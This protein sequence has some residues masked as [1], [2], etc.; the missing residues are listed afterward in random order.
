MQEKKCQK[1]RETIQEIRYLNFASLIFAFD[2]N[3]VQ[4]YFAKKLYI[5]TACL[6]TGDEMHIR[7][8]LFF[9]LFFNF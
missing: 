4:I 5:N 8:D 3:F 1:F 6:K 2:W 7:V 9:S